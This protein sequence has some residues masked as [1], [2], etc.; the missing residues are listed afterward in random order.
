ME[1]LT[2]YKLKVAER[3]GSKLEDLLH[4][5][6]PWRGEDCGRE[7]C[8]LCKTKEKTGKLKTQDC[9][10]R[11]LV[12]EMWCG[13][14]LDREEKKIEEEDEDEK[15][16]EKRKAEI[17]IYKYIGETSRSTYES[18][19]EHQMNYES[20]NTNS[21]MLK[22]WLDVHEGEELEDGAF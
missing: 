14:C 19:I 2:G 18:A 11:S 1:S 4:R 13:K 7:R 12:Y 16:R 17:R 21:Y 3:A 20:L 10:K 9:K 5:S 15:G 8:L 22:H 6:D